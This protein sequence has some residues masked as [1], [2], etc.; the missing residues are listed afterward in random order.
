[1][2][3]LNLNLTIAFSYSSSLLIIS[4]AFDSII[5]VSSYVIWA[6]SISPSI[7]CFFYFLLACLN[8][9]LTYEVTIYCTRCSSL[10]DLAA[11]FCNCSSYFSNKLSSCICF[12]F[13]SCSCSSYYYKILSCSDNSKSSFFF[14]SDLKSFLE[15]IIFNNI[16]SINIF[17]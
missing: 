11:A 15:F 2:D 7:I 10:C 13:C 6:A 5:F 4:W 8:Y 12:Y 9:Y 14:W 16:Y 1:L 3:W 17:L